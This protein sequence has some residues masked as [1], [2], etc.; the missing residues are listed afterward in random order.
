MIDRLAVA[1]R[2]QAT[3]AT[4]F[5]FTRQGYVVWHAR[6]TQ[7]VTVVQ[8][9]PLQGQEKQILLVSPEKSER[10]SSCIVSVTELLPP[11]RGGLQFYTVRDWA[12]QHTTIAAFVARYQGM[13][14]YCLGMNAQQRIYPTS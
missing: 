2:L 1:E 14:A 6:H 8:R 12:K 13:N 4:G 7:Y 5:F 3:S 11:T 10:V 9:H